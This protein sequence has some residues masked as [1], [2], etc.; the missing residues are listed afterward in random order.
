MGLRSSSLEILNGDKCQS[1]IISLSRKGMACTG[2]GKDETHLLLRIGPPR[3][4][5]D[6][7][8]HSLLLVCVKRDIVEGT[9]WHTIF[10]DIDSVLKS[11]GRANLSG[12]ILCRSLAVVTA[13][14]GQ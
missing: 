2:G 6:H 9:Q 4:L 12:S 14:C 5:H 11:M 10:L 1:M 13:P 8:E 7:V 3:Y